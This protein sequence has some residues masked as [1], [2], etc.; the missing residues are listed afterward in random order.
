MNDPTVNP[1]RPRGVSATTLILTA[2]LAATTTAAVV[3]AVLYFIS[4]RPTGAPGQPSAFAGLTG[5]GPTPFVQKDAVKPQGH[6]SGEV[7]YPIPYA[8]P[9]HL[10]LTAPRRTYTIVKQDEL[11]FSWAADNLVEDFVGDVKDIAASLQN[12][13][14]GFLQRKPNVEY[15]EFTWET[16]GV[17]ATPKR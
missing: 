1:P 6:P 16:K 2:A 8:T 15:E 7:F 9:P 4:A 3:L 13:T 5:S 12:G 10:T 17:S 14:V 11:G